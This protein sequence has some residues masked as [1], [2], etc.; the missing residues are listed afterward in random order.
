RI[1]AGHPMLASSPASILNQTA[2]DLGIPFRFNPNES[3]SRRPWR[4]VP[5]FQTSARH[6]ESVAGGPPDSVVVRQHHHAEKPHAQSGRAAVHQPGARI[7]ET[8]D[9]ARLANGHRMS[10]HGPQQ[11]KS[12][13]ASM[14]AIGGVSG[15]IMLA[16]SLAARD[17]GC[18]K[19]LVGIMI[20]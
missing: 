4:G 13:S 9:E 5:P 16:P 6:I 10:L 7:N 17:P 12:R 8:D 11:R 15:L 3:G 14:S 2:P 1:G 20:P 19:T 18:V